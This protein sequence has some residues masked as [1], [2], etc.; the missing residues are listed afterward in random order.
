MLAGT[1]CGDLEQR[2]TE[3]VPATWRAGIPPGDERLRGGPFHRDARPRAFAAPRP[4]F[5]PGAPAAGGPP[6]YAHLMGNPC[7]WSMLACDRGLS[8]PSEDFRTPRRP[9][10]PSR[11]RRRARRGDAMDAPRRLPGRLAP[12]PPPGP[13]GHVVGRLV[14]QGRRPLPPVRDER[15]R[16]AGRRGAASERKDR[17]GLTGGRVAL[18]RAVGVR[19]PRVVSE[20]APQVFWR[21]RGRGR[22]TTTAS[23][24]APPS[25]RRR[26]SSARAARPAPTSASAS[27]S[28]TTGARRS[29]TTPRRRS[30]RRPSATRTAGRSRASSG[31]RG[32]ASSS[33]PAS[34]P[35]MA[36]TASTRGSASS[37]RPRSRPRFLTSP[38]MRTCSPRIPRECVSL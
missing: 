38:S 27:S 26:T 29:S 2:S 13:G 31:A 22:A 14:E 10:T 21:R 9:C 8:R 32:T 34:I 15:A 1:G 23:C 33:T 36:G 18:A 20:R 37:T 5:A 12:R 30:W 28:A 19:F 24:G 6:A 11:R 4:D 7:D 3:E 25:Q 16:D 17:S 35:Y